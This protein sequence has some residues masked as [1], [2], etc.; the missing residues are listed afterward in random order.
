MA[1]AVSSQEVWTPA[2]AAATA[3]SE[4]NDGGTGKVLD[5]ERSNASFDVY[6]MTCY[7]EGGK[8]YATRKQWIQDAHEDAEAFVHSEIPRAELIMRNTKHFFDVHDPHFKRGFKPKEQDMSMMSDVRMTHSPP[9]AINFGV[10]ASTLRGQLSDEQKEWWLGPCQK[11]SIIG[12]YAQTELSHGSNMR[13]MQTT[14]TYDPSTEEWVLNTPHVGATKWWSSGMPMATHAAVLAQVMT[15]G[16]NH[17]ISWFLVQLRGEDLRPLPGIEVGDVGTMMGENDTPVGFLIMKNVRVHRRCLMEKRQHVTRD[18]VYTLGPE[19][20][21]MKSADSD[22]PKGPP[23]SPKMVQALKYMT[24]L[25]ERIMLANTAAGCLARA[26][27]IAARYSCVRRQGFQDNSA[28]SYDSPENQIIDYG[29]Q[30]HRVLR[31]TAVAYAMKS[32]VR[33][34]L[35][36]RHSVESGG[37]FDLAAMPELHATT[38]GFKVYCGVVASDGIEDLRRSCG[39]HG[40]LM[41]SGIAP[42][43]VDMKGPMVT[44]GG[45]YVILA[46]QTARYLVK[47]YE[48]ARRGEPV[49]GELGA[50]MQ[51]L[52]DEG[53]NIVRDGRALMG[54][55]PTGESASLRQLPFLVGLF[56]FRAVAAVVRSG[57]ALAKLRASGL[58]QDEAWNKASPVLFRA[59]LAHVRFFVFEKFVASIQ[60]CEDPNC[61]QVLERLALVFALSDIQSG[62]Q[63]P[64][65]LQYDEV[66]MSEEILDEVISELRPDVVPINDA[67]NFSDR[68]LNSTIGRSDGRVYE[69]LLKEAR[70][71]AL[72]WNDEGNK[73]EVPIFVQALESRLDKDILAW[74]NFPPSAAKL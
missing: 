73:E 29:V 51:P 52:K 19:P 3:D 63:W 2:D 56:Q 48:A 27:T 64:G 26:S 5:E 35:A 69:H 70:L 23:P 50:C 14:A 44:G 53:F 10:F 72:N 9:V 36:F 17:G 37:E 71:S 25:K 74:R 34:V 41:S 1:K 24:L 61:R 18:G 7:L 60:T 21:S 30:R 55:A 33:W 4:F 67:W 40:Y 6:A 39:G 13:G 68:V 8:K 45:D 22:K 42:L 66:I 62:D 16:K 32:A 54:C 65:L 58:S 47:C 28:S 12:C 31:W 20:G 49:A 57:E 46:L 59:A 15:Q 43:E 38:S 11:G